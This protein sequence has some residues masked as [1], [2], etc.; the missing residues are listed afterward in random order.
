MFA[1][2]IGEGTTCG[3]CFS[4]TGI[5]TLKLLLP[6]GVQACRTCD[7]GDHPPR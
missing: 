5:E 2:A 7:Q 6:G 3:L 1:T 4:R